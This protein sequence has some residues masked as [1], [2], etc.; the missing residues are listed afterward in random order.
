LEEQVDNA[1]EM[2]FSSKHVLFE[3]TNAFQEF[4]RNCFLKSHGKGEGYSNLKK[5]RKGKGA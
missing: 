4:E 5:N 3:M 2:V 1:W